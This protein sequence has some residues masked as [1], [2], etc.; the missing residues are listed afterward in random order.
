MGHERFSF[1]FGICCMGMGGGRGRELLEPVFTRELDLRGKAGLGLTITGDEADCL[2]C[3][4]E[5]VKRGLKEAVGIGGWEA[6]SILLDLL[7][8][9]ED[10]FEHGN[11]ERKEE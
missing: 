6:D 9:L 5:G 3:E 10:I 7:G 8:G 1:S 4:P 2:A 11:K